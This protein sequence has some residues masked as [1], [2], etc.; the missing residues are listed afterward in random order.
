[1]PHPQA[2]H[3]IMD[4][5]ETLAL[6]SFGLGGKVVYR[7]GVGTIAVKMPAAWSHEHEG[8]AVSASIPRATGSG[9]AEVGRRATP[10]PARKSL[11]TRTFRHHKEQAVSLLFRQ[12]P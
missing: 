8:G 1:M 5:H 9:L 7:Y 4:D 6:V 10:A 3:E 2:A 12:T 11:F